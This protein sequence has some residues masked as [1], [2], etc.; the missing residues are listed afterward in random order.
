MVSTALGK[1]TLVNVASE[2]CCD[3]ALVTPP[4]LPSLHTPPHSTKHS[5]NSS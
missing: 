4:A 2:A 1:H 5:L 3:V